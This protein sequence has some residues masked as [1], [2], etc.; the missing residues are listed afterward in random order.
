MNSWKMYSINKNTSSQPS[1]RLN[2]KFSCIKNNIPTNQL[3]YRGHWILLISKNCNCPNDKAPTCCR[4]CWELKYVALCF[5]KGVEN[6]YLPRAGESLAIWGSL[7]LRK[8]F[9]LECKKLI[10]VTDHKP[11]LGIFS[12]TNFLTP[13]TT[14]KSADYNKRHLI[15]VSHSTQPWKMELGCRCIL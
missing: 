14:H 1:S 8:L 5:T 13:L 2:Q 9:V 12:R 4:E 3:E 6:N 7:N 10:I 11:L 15:I